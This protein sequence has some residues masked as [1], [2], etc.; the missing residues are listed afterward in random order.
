MW[1]EWDRGGGRQIRGLDRTEILRERHFL[2]KV[3]P[4]SKITGS[5]SKRLS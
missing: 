5:S 4:L 3:S 2:L 1:E